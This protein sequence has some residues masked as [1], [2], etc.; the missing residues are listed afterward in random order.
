MLLTPVLTRETVECETGRFDGYGLRVQEDIDP[1]RWG[2]IISLIR[3][4]WE[5]GKAGLRIYESKTGN[6]GWKR[7]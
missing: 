2:A 1:E 5:I 7:V 6:G 3:E 4:T